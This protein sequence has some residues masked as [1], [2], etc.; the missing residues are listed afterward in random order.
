MKPPAVLDRLRVAVAVTG[1]LAVVLGS[2]GP[3]MAA[4]PG[5]NG[6]IAYAAYDEFS[7]NIW[8]M[9]A[10]GSGRTYLAA[11]GDQE[12]SPAFS[13]DGRR[14]VYTR[15]RSGLTDIWVMNADGTGQTNLTPG[16]GTE[17]GAAWSPDGTRIAFTSYR[18]GDWD[19]WVMNADGSG[20]TNLTRSPGH[21][22]G[23]TWSPD[24]T[25]LAFSSSREYATLRSEVYVM[26]A[27]GSGQTN[28]TRSPQ[29][30]GSPDWSP[31]GG[32][33][34]FMSTR[35]GWGE[36]YV[37]NTDGT[38][39]T[40]L[41]RRGYSD[42]DPSW[43]PDG[44][45]IVYTRS[46]FSDTDIHVMN[47]DGSGQTD[48]S[49]SVDEEFN[50]SWGLVPSADLAVGLVASP[51]P[52]RAQ[53]PLTYTIKVN[54][55]GPSNA[56]GVVVTDDLPANVSFVSATPSKGSCQT[57][58][59]GEHGTVTCNLGFLPRAQSAT[60]QLVVKVLAPRKSSISSTATVTSATPD[61]NMANNAAAIT[62]PVK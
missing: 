22:G 16:A 58:P 20:Q 28:L 6:K 3:A 51:E 13:P 50:P 8:V 12:D 60:A 48:I 52:A 25:R 61:P 55:I 17:G 46:E 27:D 24:G 14:I 9:N 29:E 53:K 62:T 10:D 42:F 5:L 59:I 34:A 1:A 23:A 35:N 21:D 19:V 32:K 7:S 40:N 15:G 4:F 49:Q 43:S 31:D 2:A 44:S 30:D 33:I 56:A 18:D 26:H 39:Q 54:N 38:G 37:M 36:I 57:P 11:S 45:K 47:A 41:T